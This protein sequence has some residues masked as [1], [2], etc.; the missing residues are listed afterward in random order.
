MG[1]MIPSTKKSYEL[2]PSRKAIDGP[3]LPI[4]VDNRLRHSAQSSLP[5]SHRGEK[6]PQPTY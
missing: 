3:G 2:K 5:K 4:S 6:P 1:T